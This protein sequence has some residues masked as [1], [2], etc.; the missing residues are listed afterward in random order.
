MA[1]DKPRHSLNPNTEVGLSGW[2]VDPAHLDRSISLAVAVDGR[3]VATLLATRPR[4]G[5]KKLYGGDG[6]HGFVSVLPLE[7]YD[8]VAKPMRVERTDTGEVLFDAVAPF[9]D[10]RWSGTV[11]GLMRAGKKGLE[12]WVVDRAD[13][14]APVAVEVWM[15]GRR[16][17]DLVADQE[18]DALPYPEGPRRR[19]GFAVAWP[20]AALDGAEHRFDMRLAGQAEA[21]VAIALRPDVGTGLSWA[22]DLTVQDGRVSGV[23][24]AEGAGSFAAP[25]LLGAG[26]TVLTRLWVR[27]GQ[28]IDAPL[29]GDRPTALDGPLTATL[30]GRDVALGFGA[31]GSGRWIADWRLEPATGVVEGWAVDLAGP[32]APREITLVVDGA[33]VLTTVA[34]LEGGYRFDLADAPIRA[35]FSEIETISALKARHRRQNRGPVDH[36]RDLPR[37]RRPGQIDRP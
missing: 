10:L 27:S 12:G 32:P 21:M 34:G 8:G 11:S 23:L 25:L 14:D 30:D 33:S 22:G 36:Q 28:R 7:L 31:D 35:P 5:V 29:F 17:F 1:D 15:D 2:A 37:R 4:N 13:P 19:H 24:L 9:A 6:R 3:A 20:G 16:L 26:E 18:T